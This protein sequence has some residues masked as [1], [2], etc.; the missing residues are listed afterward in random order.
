MTSETGKATGMGLATTFV[1]ILATAVT[2]PLYKFVMVPLG[3][4]FLQ[5]LFFILVIASLVQ[6]VEFYLKKS[7]PG[8]Y[9]SMGIY[10]SLIT[11]NCAVLGVTINCIG[12]NYNY[13]QSIVYALGT[14]AGFLMSMVIMSGVR[15]KLRTAKVPAAFKGTPILY[16][17]AGLLSLAFLGFKGLIK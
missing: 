5:T 14:A 8:L 15:S 1:I 11:T 10:L 2:W 17:A 6:L 9:S 13:G 7:A 16:V 4:E 12:K 3:L